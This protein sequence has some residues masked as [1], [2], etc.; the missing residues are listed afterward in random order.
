MHRVSNRAGDGTGQDL[1]AHLTLA[2][3]TLSRSSNAQRA[4][5][6]SA[7]V[8][9]GLKPLELPWRGP[10]NPCLQEVAALFVHGQSLEGQP[11]Y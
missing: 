4:K 11:L 1:K 10:K 2:K 6:S 3:L 8:R 7:M 5:P 9:S